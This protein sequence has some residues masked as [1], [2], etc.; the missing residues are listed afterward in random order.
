M[1]KFEYLIIGGGIAGTTAAET[2][3]KNDEKGTIAV[4]SEESEPLYS[5][6]TLHHYLK[7]LIPF[8]RLYLRNDNFYK[9]KKIELFKGKKAQKLDV[10]KKEIT[11]DDGQVFGFDKLLIATG[12]HPNQWQV[13]GED[14]K[15]VFC[16]RT[17][18]DAKNIKRRIEKIKTINPHVV[19]IGGSFIA[20]DLV[21]SFVKQGLKTT[22]LVR[23]DYFLQNRLD[24]ECAKLIEDILRKNNIEVLPHEEVEK[25]LGDGKVE[26]VRL[27][28]GKTLKAGMV[29]VGIGI[30]FGLEWLKLAGISTNRGILANEYLETNI[31]GVFC[32]GDCCEFWDV[33]SQTQHRVGNW[34]N[35]Q[36]QGEAAGLN[37]CG[38]KTIYET[39]S[40]YSISFFDAN[41][42]F[43]G[44]TDLDGASFAVTRGARENGSL[45]HLFLKNNRLVGAT[46]V[47]RL[48]EQSSIA[49]LIKNKVD[50]SV[51]LD[52][53]SDPNF[54]LQV[55]L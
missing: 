31:P 43:C 36:K 17:I 46:L 48:N 30:N 38:K 40:T 7:D 49:A 2:I 3:R 42:C 10:S 15:G 53:L 27:K 54:D 41:A 22:I 33:L 34:Q 5:R 23:R 1:T 14:E 47:N 4:I 52:K 8:E 28:S 6:L 19:I 11:L 18:Q 44:M 24:E 32:A 12:G 55:L 29:A 35:A 21:T 37:M 51:V 16:F 39:V 9:E 20:L 26:G 50:L 13:K 45:G 25:V